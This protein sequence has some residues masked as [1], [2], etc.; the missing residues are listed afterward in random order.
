[1]ALLD[2]R[3]FLTITSV[4][5]LVA[6]QPVN[7]ATQETS[8]GS[9]VP[10]TANTTVGLVPLAKRLQDLIADPAVDCPRRIELSSLLAA[11][12]FAQHRYGDSESTLQKL[13]DDTKCPLD[14]T[15]K[16]AILKHLGD[17]SYKQRDFSQAAKSYSD[18]LELSKTTKISP[19]Q[20]T[21][22]LWSSAGTS[23]RRGDY[24]EAANYYEQVGKSDA[25]ST[26]GRAWLY[27][28]LADTYEALED[29]DSAQRLFSLSLDQFKTSLKSGPQIATTAA[30]NTS[31]PSERLWHFVYGIPQASPIIS[32]TTP[33]K[34]WAAV[35]CIHG[36]GL[37]SR[38]FDSLGTQLAK[39]GILAFAM[40]M[41]GFGAW[42]TNQGH[43]TLQYSKFATD[44]HRA[45]QAI[46]QS[47]PSLPFFLL[48]ESM[49]G[50]IVLRSAA[51]NP[52]DIDGLISSVPAAGRHNQ[53]GE[54]IEVARHFIVDPEHDFDMGDQ[55]IDVMVADPH[56]QSEL[57]D[58]PRDRLDF[59]AKDLI[60]FNWFMKRSNSF[61]GK[62]VK[63][64]LITQGD[65]DRLVK[66]SSTIDL[67]HKIKIKDRNLLL[68]GQNQHLIFEA[69]QF[70]DLLLHGVITWMRGH[71]TQP[72][73]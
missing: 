31:S 45:C 19:V 20:L 32:W 55:L 69:D 58:D 5:M 57:R 2:R 51:T 43:E 25:V 72:T 68:L 12:Y 49:G 54:A 16:V 33:T 4:A 37:D 66:E 60:K 56:T 22:L 14:T 28:N 64:V 21:D 59:S 29:T 23:F 38:S 34:P 9:T 52:K 11:V 36:F 73:K 6:G 44:V 71:L 46:R 3:T 17:C 1:M 24:K 48:G 67:F 41:R 39:Q 8:P 63:P 27:I 18:S 42:Q 65:E 50:A 15:T 40:D 30:A 13:R 35:L 7:A 10:S 26:L 61:A 53:L 62:L 47:N 70:S